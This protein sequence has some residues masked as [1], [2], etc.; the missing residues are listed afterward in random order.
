MLALLEGQSDL[1]FCIR[2]ISG[3]YCIALCGTLLT[4]MMST[5]CGIRQ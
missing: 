3:A 4:I 1:L 5:T 2:M